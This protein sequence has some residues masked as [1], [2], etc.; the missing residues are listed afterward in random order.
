VIARLP[1]GAGPTQPAT[2]PAAAMTNHPPGR[3]T[4]RQ[5]VEYAVM[6]PSAGNSQPW[7]FE[8]ST[9]T[10]HLRCRLDSA[11]TGGALDFA[12]RASHA[13]LGAALENI[14]I[15]AAALGF[16][17]DVRAADAAG[18]DAQADVYFLEGERPGVDA[19]LSEQIPRRATRRAL[20]SGS[21]LPE[22][23]RRALEAEA[24]VHGGQLHW[25]DSRQALAALGDVVG[26]CDR[27]RMCNETLHGEL[28]AEARWTPEAAA[29]T[30]DGIDVRTMEL[31]RGQLFLLKRLSKW[32]GVRALARLGIER[33]FEE[34]GTAT[35]RHSSAVALLTV[36]GTTPSST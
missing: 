10:A 19:S 6:A 16:L 30:G 7:C 21:A 12:Q 15:G 1:S 26:A 34:A 14:V 22:T 27:I 23:T 35:V 3:E 36:R 28:M 2:L 13:A 4:L 5:L 31:S 32:Q 17:T 18:G 20:G 9:R 8:S 24:A 25:A 11:R 33:P 29:A